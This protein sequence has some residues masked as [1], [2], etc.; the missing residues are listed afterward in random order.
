MGRWDAVIDVSNVCWDEQ[1]PP[2]GRRAPAWGR[3]ELVMAAWR[4]QHGNAARFS[5]VADDALLHDLDDAWEYGRLLAAGELVTA[6][7][8]DAEILALARD[9]HLHVITRDRFLQHR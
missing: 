9:H 8:A 3:L 2:R 6:P 1:L 4:R 5:L 7:H